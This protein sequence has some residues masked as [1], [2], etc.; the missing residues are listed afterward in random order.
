[1]C[2]GAKSPVDDYQLWKLRL[3]YEPPFKEAAK[4][5]KGPGVQQST[6]CNRADLQRTA[7]RDGALRVRGAECALCLG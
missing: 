3:V 2:E 5:E 1:M 6:C 7:S 4:L